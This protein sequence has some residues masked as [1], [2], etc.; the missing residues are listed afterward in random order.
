MFPSNIPKLGCGPNSCIFNTWTDGELTWKI[1]QNTIYCETSVKTV[2]I[3][4]QHIRHTLLWHT[5]HLHRWKWVTKYINIKY[6]GLYA[7]MIRYNFVKITKISFFLWRNIKQNTVNQTILLFF[8]HFC[9]AYD[10]AF[11]S[12][13]IFKEI[14][15]SIYK[16]LGCQCHLLLLKFS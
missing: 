11:S 5:S 13:S 9:Y 2:N 8:W 6:C 12:S 1:K 14:Q 16:T 15:T 4:I 7:N 10:Y 3:S